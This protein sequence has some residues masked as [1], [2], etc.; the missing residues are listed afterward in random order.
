MQYLQLKGYS[1]VDTHPT[2]VNFEGFQTEYKAFL[3]ICNLWK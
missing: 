2:I 1:G 3:M